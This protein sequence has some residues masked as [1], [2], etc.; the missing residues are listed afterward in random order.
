M[1]TTIEKKEIISIRRIRELR[2]RNSYKAYLERILDYIVSRARK[3]LRR[4]KWHRFVY[5]DGLKPNLEDYQ[6]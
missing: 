1:L 6:L 2:R 5:G 3:R 4:K